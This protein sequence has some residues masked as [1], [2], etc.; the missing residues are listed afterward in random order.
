MRALLVISFLLLSFP[1]AF[2]QS[3][4][5]TIQQYTTKDGLSSDKIYALHKGTRGFI[6][7]GTDAGLN[8]FDGTTFKM[9]SPDNQPDM[10]ISTIHEIFEDDQGYLWLL[11]KNEI[12]EEGYQSPELNLFHLVTGEITT[13]KK[14]FGSSMPF[15]AK[16]IHFMKKLSD[17]QLYFYCDRL[18]KGFVYSSSSGFKPLNI[19]QEILSV[20][21]M[22]L[23]ADGHF[24]IKG[25]K[26]SSSDYWDIYK[27]DKE[28]NI[29]VQK[30]PELVVP[31]HKNG[32]IINAKF[33]GENYFIK[34]YNL[35][36]YNHFSPN[37]T[38]NELEQNDGIQ[39]NQTSWN[40]TQQLLWIFNR[41]QIRVINPDGK[42]VFEQKEKLDDK[43]IPIFFDGHTAWLS[44]KREGLMAIQL[45]PNYF[46]NY[47]FFK[48]DLD[49]STR[50]IYQDRNGK[51]WISTINGSAQIFPNG[52]VLTEEKV[53]NVYT[54][55]L[56][57]SRGD[58]WYF[59]KY[60][61]IKYDFDRAKETL[62]PMEG[63]YAAWSLLEKDSDEIWFSGHNGVILKKN[64]HSE[65]VASKALLPSNL[66]I[67]FFI[68][69]YLPKD[70]ASFWLCTNQGLYVMSKNGKTLEI[71]NKDQE[72]ENYLPANAFHHIYQEE[73]GTIWLATGNAGLLKLKIED[74]KLKI[75]QQ[76]TMENGLS[77]NSIHAIY[78]DDFDYLWMSSDNG[79]M[80][81]D[82]QSEKVYHYF[83]EDG[84]PHNEFNRIAHHRGKDGQLFFG[85]LVGVTTFH[86]KHFAAIRNQ[87][88]STPLVI[89][90]FQQ[91]SG[92]EEKFVDLTSDLLQ[93]QT[94]TLAPSDQ[95][96]NLDIALLDFSNHQENTYQYRIKKLYDWKSN[97]TG[98][99]NIS[100]LP[101]GKH[102]LEVRTSNNSQHEAA[103][104]LRIAINVLKPFYL[105]SW[106][107]IVLLG[108]STFG[109][110]LLMNKRTQFLKNRQAVKRIPTK[111]KTIEEEKT[112]T[113]SKTQKPKVKTAI[114]TIKG[115]IVQQ[116]LEWLEKV[117]Q[118]ALR[119]VKNPNF[120]IDDLAQE[121]LVSRR[122]L[123]RKIKKNQ[124]FTPKK[125]LNHIRI[126]KA[127][128]IL[129]TEDVLT[130][131]EV[132]YA[133]GFEN[134]SY[135]A[136]LYEAEFGK[137]PHDL[138][139]K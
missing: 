15:D 81:F 137:R 18:R 24:L 32:N 95:L 116:D 99:L 117:E 4:I 25:R 124:G 76:Y 34:G 72:G 35:D 94:I 65:R 13:P 53:A 121:L 75:E 119:E 63:G 101:Y 68:Y 134:A 70:S 66:E 111:R 36:A 80:Q 26:N 16:D 125:Y 123:F 12:Y 86:P 33:D 109:G 79:L 113:T 126:K 51:I 42:I 83:E 28:G 58:L 8:R 55:Y 62:F 50:G 54:R 73:D 1:F 139:K 97:T 131:T 103:N 127:K 47:R 100:G 20:G 138:L 10:T 77:S 98:Q 23:Q 40:K 136:K 71:Y 29:L 3:Y 90:A 22:I 88:N 122:Q 67:G 132:S 120:T 128:N 60:G 85:G 91:F 106:F 64:R 45:Q 104:D 112:L 11:K 114:S 93:T 61:L 56:E 115:E 49:N 118:I 102:I 89:T 14:K 6:W 38:F 110:W 74:K 44:N 31:L 9:Y 5:P 48:Q 108:L 130:L 2:S 107:I 78:E 59:N 52:Q 87:K 46:T 135:F 105:Q 21:D 69:E 57:D 7:I 96:I 129:E 133:V 41:E 92:E 19:P 37:L 27:A 17:G 39:I 43:Q 84:I 82:K 30:K